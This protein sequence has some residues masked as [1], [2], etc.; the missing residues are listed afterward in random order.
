MNLNMSEEK[1]AKIASEPAVQPNTPSIMSA[2]HDKG[3][4]E[5]T[6][7]GIAVLVVSVIANV[8]LLITF[9]SQNE[10]LRQCESEIEDYKAITTEL[11]EQLNKLD[12]F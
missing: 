4:T 6:L 2:P 5:K 9:L 1:L 10:R 12:K 7:I 8:I 11:K 3:K